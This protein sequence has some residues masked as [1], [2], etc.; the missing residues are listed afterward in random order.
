MKVSIWQ[1][2]SS[3]HSSNFTIIG[4]LETAEKAQ[5]IA[6]QFKQIFKAILQSKFDL[7]S[8]SDEA[9]EPTR[10]EIAL[11]DKYQIDS[12]T[13][14]IDWLIPEWE[15]LDRP[16]VEHWKN[17]VLVNNPIYDMTNQIPRNIVALMARLAND[18]FVEIEGGGD[19]ITFDLVAAAPNDET[20]MSV[21]TKIKAIFALELHRE[22]RN[23]G[24]IQAQYEPTIKAAREEGDHIKANKLQA[25]I[26]EIPVLRLQLEEAAKAEPVLPVDLSWSAITN[27]FLSSQYTQGVE[28][29]GNL[30]RLNDVDFYDIEHLETLISW[31]ESKG[32]QDVKVTLDGAFGDRL[33][34]PWGWDI[35]G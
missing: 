20:A 7:R 6:D 5:E 16:V 11:R 8:R 32:F 22:E 19:Y 10:V 21:E 35:N 33:A 29:K 31:F 3:N 34:R 17:Y 9:G 24:V 28:R 23:Q 18:V 25:E 12:W 15:E 26:D 2:F 13:Q 27:P 4:Q 1:Q 30:I 14:S